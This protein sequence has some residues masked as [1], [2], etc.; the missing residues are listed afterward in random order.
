MSTP[1]DSGPLLAKPLWREVDPVVFADTILAAAQRIG[2]QPLAVEKDYWVCEALRAVEQK[3]PNEVLFKGGTSLEKLRIIQRFSEDLDLLVVATYPNERAAKRSM[4][5]MC[6]A[7]ADAAGGAL[8]DERSGGSLGAQWRHA[9]LSPPLKH[10]TEYE[11]SLADP[12]RILLE[13]GQSGGTLPSSRRTVE[14]LL[15]RE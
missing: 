9:Y 10:R 13:F 7:A 4:K 3:V 14:S 1:A 5:S 11:S 2:V 6:Q 12:G 15:A 8:T